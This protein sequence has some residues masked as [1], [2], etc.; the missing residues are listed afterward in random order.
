MSDIIVDNDINDNIGV[1]DESNQESNIKN[2]QKN[3]QESSYTFY[4][5][6]I[7]VG[8]LLYL[9]Y[10]SYVCIIETQ[11]TE[12]FIEKTIKTGIDVDI[13]F[14]TVGEVNKLRELQENYLKSIAHLSSKTP[15]I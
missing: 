5:S 1:I 10:Y 14:D 12:P 7:V 6:I 9:V 15:L 3:I 11:E 4:L 2:N 13:A 8:L